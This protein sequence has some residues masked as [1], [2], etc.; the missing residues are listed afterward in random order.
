MAYYNRFR[1]D[2][3]EQIIIDVADR[4]QALVDRSRDLQPENVDELLAASDDDEATYEMGWTEVQNPWQPTAGDTMTVRPVL[5]L[6]DGDENPEY[7]KDHVDKGVWQL[8]IEA[9]MPDGNPWYMG[10]ITF[11]Y[12]HGKLKFDEPSISVNM[13]I[14]GDEFLTPVPWESAD[15]QLFMAMAQGALDGQ[16]S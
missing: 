12:S 2:D 4:R 7:E 11:F 9:C 14:E 6:S 15:A 3:P 16:S 10:A 13:V 8:G 5:F 1:G